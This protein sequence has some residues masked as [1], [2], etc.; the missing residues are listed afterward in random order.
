VL[1]F[2]PELTIQT[3][4][5]GV[6]WGPCIDYAITMF[7]VAMDKLAT[8]SSGTPGK[9]CMHGAVVW[10]A[11]PYPRAG[12]SRSHSHEHCWLHGGEGACVAPVTSRAGHRSQTASSTARGFKPALFL[13][14]ALRCPPST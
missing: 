10:G 3:S 9:A 12:P 4:E 2:Y 6:V 11:G 5:V 14:H 1:K 13:S 8:P 7:S